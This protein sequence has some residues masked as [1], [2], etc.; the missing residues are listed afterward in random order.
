MARADT[1]D[2]LSS[3]IENLAPLGVMTPG[4]PLRAAE[5]NSLV[6]ALRT[7]ARLAV[8]RERTTDEYLD[9]RYARIDHAHVGQIGLEWFEP[10][11]RALLDQ[12]VSGAVEQR[13]SLKATRDE[14]AQLRASVEGLRRQLTDLRADVDG[15]RDADTARLRDIDRVAVRV[16]SLRNVEGRVAGLDQRLGTMS[17]DLQAALEFRNE[18]RDEAGAPVNVREFGQRIAALEGLRENLR[19][20]DGE[21]V[22]IREIESAIAR[23][24]DTILTRDALNDAVLNG[25][26]DPGTIAQSGL[27]ENVRGLVEST[28]AD[29][30]GAVES[31]TLQ[32]GQEIARVRDDLTAQAA[33]LAEQHTRLAAAEAELA[34]VPALAGRLDQQQAQLTSGES[35]LQGI[36]TATADLPAIRIQL[37]QVQLQAAGMG[38]LRADLTQLGGRVGAVEA[39]VAT[40]DGLVTNVQ[41]T[42]TRVAAIEQALPA[43]R[44]AADTVPQHTAALA[45]IDTRLL[46]AEAELDNAGDLAARFQGVDRQL[47]E[48]TA[49]QGTALRRL[50]ELASRTSGLESVG[51]RL[52]AVESAAAEQRNSLAHVTGNVK[53]VEARLASTTE[54]FD[55][56]ITALEKSVFG[57]RR[58]VG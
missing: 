27:V 4:R 52:T 26:R 28:F 7:M 56:R 53:Q 30:F 41:Q 44:Q 55:T 17:A 36:Q 3:L 11:A 39:N 34:S 14:I 12:G 47:R 31:S 21:T 23:L 58:P 37:A 24:E 43:L 33:R 13:A 25:L 9:D 8:S 16:E 51:S 15:L 32:L 57:P 46:A 40:I 48:L 50:D 1:I 38:G 42:T 29:R 22:Q 10:S 35:R 45:Q 5:W 6:E 54:T 49:S 19:T 20:A 18:L 2:L